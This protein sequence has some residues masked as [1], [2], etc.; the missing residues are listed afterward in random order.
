MPMC[1]ALTQRSHEFEYNIL[2]C[3]AATRIDMCALSAICRRVVFQVNVYSG[4][5]KITQMFE[6]KI[7]I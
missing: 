4:R 2:I 5:F 6:G 1:L 3:A 7:F